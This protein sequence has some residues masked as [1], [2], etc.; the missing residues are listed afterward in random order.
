MQAGPQ[1]KRPTKDIHMNI[2]QKIDRVL[3]SE[4]NVHLPMNTLEEWIFKNGEGEILAINTVP[5]DMNSYEVKFYPSHDDFI[6]NQGGRK[7]VMGKYDLSTL[8]K[9]DQYGRVDIIK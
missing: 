3:I 8:I 6:N 2:L 9:R 4:I 1:R 7:E 5:D